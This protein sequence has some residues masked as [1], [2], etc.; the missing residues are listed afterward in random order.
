[1]DG[2]NTALRICGGERVVALAS[3]VNRRWDDEASA[4][5]QGI[6]GNTGSLGK[7]C[8]LVRP[9][10]GMPKADSHQELAEIAHGVWCASRIRLRVWRSSLGQFLW[11]FRCMGSCINF[12]D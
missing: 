9:K 7:R 2:G 1:M 12:D 10:G 5:L 4:V 3:C 11:V 8:P 6:C